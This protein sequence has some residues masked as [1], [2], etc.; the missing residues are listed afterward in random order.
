MK[1]YARP[2]E[3]NHL[4]R[5][6]ETGCRTLVVIGHQAR[7]AAIVFYQAKPYAHKVTRTILENFLQ[8]ECIR[9]IAKEQL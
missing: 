4:Y 7:Y 8:M 6:G 1:A 9:A 3:T 2:L 5:P